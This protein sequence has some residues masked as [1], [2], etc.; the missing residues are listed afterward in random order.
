MDLCTPQFVQ[1]RRSL[2]ER[3]LRWLESGAYGAVIRENARLKYAL[4]S[5][6]VSWGT[7]SE[8]LLELSL[9]CI[10]A[11]HLRRYFEWLLPDLEQNRSGLPDLVQFFVRERRYRLIEVKAPGDRLQDNQRRWLDYCLQHELPVAVCQIRWPEVPASSDH[12]SDP[13]G[14]A[15]GP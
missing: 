6:F 10:P 9:S 1:R 11:A 13:C 14:A 5:P 4:Q 2:F 12:S 15:I 8:E 3:C 7:M